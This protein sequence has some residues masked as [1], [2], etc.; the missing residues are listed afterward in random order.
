MKPFRALPLLATLSFASLLAQP[1]G[2]FAGAVYYCNGGGCTGDGGN[3]D[4]GSTNGINSSKNTVNVN[5]GSASGYGPGGGNGTSNSGSQNNVS[6]PT[7]LPSFSA[8]G[9]GSRPTVYGGLTGTPGNGGAFGG[10][11]SNIGFGVGLLTAIGREPDS[12]KPPVVNYYVTAPPPGAPAALAA[13]PAPTS[14]AAAPAELSPETFAAA[15]ASPACVPLDYDV[16]SFYAHDLRVAKHTDNTVRIERD[17][18][19]LNKGCFHN[20]VIEAIASN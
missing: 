8:S 12:C 9:C 13:P 10:S 1:P 16:A 4:N 14:R 15:S 2:A 17:M 11:G 6:V 5:Y 19:I 7:Q 20:L 18:T 3:G